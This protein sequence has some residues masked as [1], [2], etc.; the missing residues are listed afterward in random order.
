[1]HDAGTPIH[2]ITCAVRQPLGT[3]AAELLGEMAVPCLFAES[4][5]A[6]RRRR[7]ARRFGF[8]GQV[9]RLDNS[10][11]EIF[12]FN[13]RPEDSQKAVGHLIAA[14]DIKL[15]GRGTVFVQEVR[16][17]AD[18]CAVGPPPATAETAPPSGLLKDLALITCIMSMSGSGEELAKLALELGTGVPM[19]TLG[20]GTGMRD[21]LGLLRITIPPEKELVH[22]LVPAL[23]AEGLMR[24]LIEE[25]RLNRPGKGF[26]YCRPVL[27]GLLDTSLQ[28]GAQEHTASM[29]QVIAAIDDL[30]SGTSWRRRFPEVDV[31]GKYWMQR[32]CDEISLV[33][34]EEQSHKFVIQAQQAG[35]GGATTARLRRLEAGETATKACE[36]C[37]VIVPKQA[38]ARVLSALLELRSNGEQM[39]SLQVQPLMLAFSHRAKARPAAS[40]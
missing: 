16:E 26:L 22:L 31:R 15:P 6:V 30:K 36:R 11:V 9:D 13:A 37:I 24:M 38:T 7:G 20:T 28:I 10:P 27:C 33:C 35:A 12:Q 4:G 21:R 25:G 3:K 40:S 14:L 39:E 5:R 19:V 34:G 29:E 18:A 2:R 32:Q 8:L 17:F 23:D 1:M